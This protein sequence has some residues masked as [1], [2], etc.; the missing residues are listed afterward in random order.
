MDAPAPHPTTRA[1]LVA[2]AREEFVDHGFAGTDSNKIA[3]RAGFAPQTFYR[4]FKDKTDI[5]LAVYGGWQRED[6]VTIGRLIGQ[7][8]TG[9][10]LAEA[11]IGLR[12]RRSRC[13]CSN[14]NA[15]PTRW[16][17]ESLPTWA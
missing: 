15:W 9:A 8:A 3:R 2:A 11:L 1:R 10:S 5:F 12:P 7:G 17:R 14:S 6:G 4:W 16:R 13:G